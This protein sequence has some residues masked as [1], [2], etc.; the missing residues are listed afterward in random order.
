MCFV[1]LLLVL[2]P[3]PGHHTV[4]VDLNFRASLFLAHGNVGFFSPYKALGELL[5]CQCSGFQLRLQGSS[6]QGA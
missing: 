5:T 3:P 6:A 1:L 2:P 4:A